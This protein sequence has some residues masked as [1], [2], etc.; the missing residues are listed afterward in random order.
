MMHTTYRIENNIKLHRNPGVESDYCG[1]LCVQFEG[2][3]D[4]RNKGDVAIERK[5]M[6]TMV[7]VSNPSL[8]FQRLVLML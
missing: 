2:N 5:M 3:V 7:F 4:A 8:H 6:M 1:M